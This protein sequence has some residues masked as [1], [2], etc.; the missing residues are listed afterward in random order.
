MYSTATILLY[1]CKC[2]ATRLHLYSLAFY[3]NTPALPFL[4]VGYTCIYCN[5]PATRLQLHSLCTLSSTL[6]NYIYTV[7]IILLSGY[8]CIQYMYC[9]RVTPIFIVLLPGYTCI[10]YP[11]TRLHLITILL[12]YKVTLVFTVLLPS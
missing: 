12:K 4:L 2:T 3:L 7:F 10:L 6:L 9:D 11:A 8:I 1:T 5:S